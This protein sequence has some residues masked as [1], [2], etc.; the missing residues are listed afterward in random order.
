MATDHKGN[1]LKGRQR[2]LNGM[3]ITQRKLLQKQPKSCLENIYSR[4]AIVTKDY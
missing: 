3:R 1:W 2:N 4:F